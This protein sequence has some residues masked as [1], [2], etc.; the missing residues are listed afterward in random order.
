MRNH[1]LKAFAG[2][3]I[4]SAAIILWQP[5]VLAQDKCLTN[6]EVKVVV[7]KINSQQNMTPNKKLANEL[8]KLRAENQKSFQEALAENLRED[9]FKKRI[10]VI[11]EKTTPRF[12]GMVKEFG[13]PTAGLVGKEGAAAA[14]YLLRNN[15][16]FG[17]QI[18]LLPVMVAAVKKDEIAKPEFAALVDRMRVDAGV[19]QLF[20]TQATVVNGLLVLFP[21]EAEAQVDVRR[22]QYGLPPLVNQL[23]SLE[24][25]YQMPLV[26]APVTMVNSF[27]SALKNSIEKSTATS[28]LGISASEEDDVVRVE[29]NLTN[30]NV[31]VYNSKSRTYVG[32]LA[33]NDFKVFEDG[34]EENVTFFAATD[35]PFDLV[36]LLDVSG[37]T[38]GKLD[39]VRKS[40]RRFVEAARPVDR[41]AIVTFSATTRVV[42]PLTADRA[43]L[44]DSIRKI[45]SEGGSNVWDALKFTLDQVV[46]SRSPDRRSAVVLMSDGVDGTL[47]LFHSPRRALRGSIISF[48]DLLEAVR[49]VDTLI[50]PI[51]LDTEFDYSQSGS[52]A[53]EYENARRTLALL[54]EESGGLYYKAQ[55]IE[56]LNGV[57][58]QVIDDLGKVYSLGYKS[59]NE[60]R[61]GSWRTV[62]IQL[63][64]HSE[65]VTRARAGYYAH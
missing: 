29:T 41:L 10:G 47:Q 57:Y 60:K 58:E 53:K 28:A 5:S 31:S 11:K 18:E 33:K 62:K 8:I 59:T 54:A 7:A 36:L 52:N 25:S 49:K 44:I 40:T 63:P 4:I 13:W 51:Y 37:S 55:R 23:R 16:T 45:E 43:A 64:N 2:L 12:C 38:A 22:K 30:V 27:S 24:A 26:K 50:I 21:I 32:S 19:K 1:S 34:R 3:L 35:V 17:L 20:G 65:L 56:D 39:L 14:F 6:D 42:S 48:A 61:N 9:L 46:G 15:V